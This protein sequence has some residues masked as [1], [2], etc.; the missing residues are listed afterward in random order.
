MTR[1]NDCLC[2]GNKKF[3]M[4]QPYRGAL[5]DGGQD[6]E[7]HEI[8]EYVEELLHR[9]TDPPGGSMLEHL[10]GHPFGS[11]ACRQ[12]EEAGNTFEAK[13]RDRSQNLFVE[14]PL[15]HLPASLLPWQRF[16]GHTTSLVNWA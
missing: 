8:H 1:S 7:L 10:K 9:V 11:T 2:N 16:V 5:L 3:V 4:V 12:Q 13:L 14:G 15:I 6:I